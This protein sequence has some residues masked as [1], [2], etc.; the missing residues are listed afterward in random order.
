MVFSYCGI[1]TQSFWPRMYS[2]VDIELKGCSFP[3]FHTPNKPP[4]VKTLELERKK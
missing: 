4:N 3:K 1:H 2:F